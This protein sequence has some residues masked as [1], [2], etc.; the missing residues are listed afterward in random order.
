MQKGMPSARE[1][2]APADRRRPGPV[3]ALAVGAAIAASSALSLGVPAVASA[4]TAHRTTVVGTLLQAYPESRHE[5]AADPGADQ[6]LSWVET[7]GG[8]A[9]RI[10]TAD[11]QG[12]PAGSTVQVTVGGPATDP[13]PTPA[14]L[15]PAQEVISSTVVATPPV[16]PAPT[17]VT[18]ERHLTNEVTIVL[19]APHGAVPDHSATVQ[20]L[21]DTVNGPVSRFWSQ[22]TNG[23]INI[24]VAA[25][26]D[27]IT[28]TAGCSTPAAMWDEVAAK[29]HFVPG[30]GKHLLLYVGGTG[31]LADCSYALGEVGSGIASGGRTYVRD[32]IPSVI[33]HE[34]GHNFGLGHSSGR[35]CDAAV[36]TGSCR[37]VG[38]RDY[39]DVMG[40]SWSQLG[41][42]NVAQ[43]ARLGVLPAAREM[44]VSV[45]DVARTVT[46]APLAARQGTRAL[47]LTDADGT[48]Y[49]LEYRAAAR[50]D[51]WL[52]TDANLY[53]LQA[54]VLL[55]RSGD[56]PDTS[57][58]LDGTPSTAAGWN[59]D[60][61][62]ALPVGSPVTV[63]AGHFAIEVQALTTAGAVVRVVPSAP[64]GAAA[65]A[66]APAPGNAGDLVLPANGTVGH[67]TATGPAP[68]DPP[69]AAARVATSAS[70][71]APASPASPHLQATATSRSS[72]GIV[73][74]LAGALLAAALM[75]AA[76]RI[77]RIARR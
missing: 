38:Y 72:L 20:Q 8:N 11:V 40:V 22:Q 21:V 34:L 75:L 15:P 2:L 18:P 56:L 69:A 58:L 28:T 26:H 73:V 43:A 50:Q 30:H 44:N 12:V 66:P 54:G 3:R 31:N 36:D 61:H 64:A 33:A 39:Y 4:D 77:R 16:L 48:Q 5:Q 7:S 25:A 71:D 9:V 53:G 13:A 70:V 37:T 65:P 41:S 27:W 74:P 19:V 49:W 46:L 68:A 24:G 45:R 42:L 59:A 52:G 60:L 14:G 67:G 10:P 51:A 6:P 23:A 62:E 35:Q 63:A 55:H 76:A 57:L 47:R 29:V 32:T 17:P 1:S